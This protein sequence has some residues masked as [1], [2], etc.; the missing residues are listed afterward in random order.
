MK[1]EAGGGESGGV[2]GGMD[3][4]SFEKER[5]GARTDVVM[6]AKSIC[7]ELPGDGGQLD[8]AARRR[9]CSVACLCA[10]LAAAGQRQR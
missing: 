5:G 9:R 4:S 2:G 6:S 1:A 3:P 10:T 7:D 8:L